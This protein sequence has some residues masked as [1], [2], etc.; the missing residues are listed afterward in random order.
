MIVKRVKTTKNY[1]LRAKR[2]WLVCGKLLK[3]T[4]NDD[5]PSKATLALVLFQRTRA[6]RLLVVYYYPTSFR[7]F[8]PLFLVCRNH[9]A[10]SQSSIFSL[11]VR[12]MAFVSNSE[13]VSEVQS[14]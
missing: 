11:S 1:Y 6:R 8:S 10:Y 3:T 14:T 12:R 7:A 9:Q 13:F 4:K 2:G 5:A